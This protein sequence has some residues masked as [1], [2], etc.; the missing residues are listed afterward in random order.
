MQVDFLVNEWNLH[1]LKG[2]A[3][4]AVEE[5]EEGSGRRLGLAPPLSVRPRRPPCALDF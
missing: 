4:L 5:S 3:S 1:F 2:R